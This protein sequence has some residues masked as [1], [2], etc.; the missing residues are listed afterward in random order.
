MNDDLLD[1]A[2]RVASQARPGEAVEALVSR[3]RD[4]EIKA[5]KG[6]IEACTIAGSALSGSL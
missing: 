5:Y 2:R 1:I 6:E 4:T 3:G